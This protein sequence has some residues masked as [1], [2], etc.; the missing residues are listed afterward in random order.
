DTAS[1]IS[2]KADRV[3]IKAD[4]A[5]LSFITVTINDKN[6]LMVPRSKNRLKFEIS[7]AGEIIATDNGD[8]TD[9]SSFQSTNRKAYNGMA[10]VIVRSIKGK[11]GKIKLKAVSDGLKS[12][13][14]T[15]LS[16]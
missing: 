16:R 13:E 15:I 4:G 1:Q 6:G 10:L 3:N 2:M 7:G 11:G 5:D 8:A 9:L 14:T 12:S